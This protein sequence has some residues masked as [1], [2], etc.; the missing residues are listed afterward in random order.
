MRSR[1]FAA[2]VFA[3]LLAACDTGTAAPAPTSPTPV[4]PATV[5]ELREVRL[6]GAPVNVEI[7]HSSA[8]K[9]AAVYSDGHLVD[10]TAEAT[11]SSSNAA[12]TVARG[13]VAGVSAGFAE[14]QAQFGGVQSVT[15]RIACGYLIT[16]ATHESE[17]TEDV[18]VSRVAGE[19]LDGALAGYKFSTDET[20]RAVLPPVA[21]PG[22]EIQFKKEDFE[23]ELIAV[24]Q[25]PLQ[26]TLDV[27]LTPLPSV[28]IEKSG[29]CSDREAGNVTF[30]QGR[31]GKIRISARLLA[32]PGAPWEPAVLAAVW[33]NGT[34]SS[35][36]L[37]A[38]DYVG[39]PPTENWVGVPRT[40]AYRAPVGT[41]DFSYSA[42]DC[43][44]GT[45]WVVVLEHMQ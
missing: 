40:A 44:P 23:N 30:V 39:S 19:V 16:V 4:T 21:A 42:S 26:T 2:G 11:W 5:P 17:P 18:V 27:A 15:V 14:I 10:V 31:P 3:L 29:V 28:R 24:R 38:I 13:T 43:G 9:A 25:L 37:Q 36:E 45:R 6:L 7:G 33:T 1:P 32:L 22:F 12:C 41:Y 34:G 20:G 35:R 8:I